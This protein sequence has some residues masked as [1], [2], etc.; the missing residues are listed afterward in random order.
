MFHIYALI[1]VL[2]LCVAQGE[3]I[4]LRPRY[5]AMTTLT[6]IAERKAT[7][8]PAVPTMLIALLAAAEASG[9][10]HDLSSLAWVGIGRRA[11]AL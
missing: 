7:S 8:F 6:D 1:V 9:V 11:A 5:D 2:M 10:K 3:E 4:L